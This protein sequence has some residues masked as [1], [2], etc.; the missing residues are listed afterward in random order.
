METIPLADGDL[1]RVFPELVDEL[2]V[3]DI[4][5]RAAGCIG[6][7]ADHLG[8]RPSWTGSGLEFHRYPDQRTGLSRGDLRAPASGGLRCGSW[9][10]DGDEQS[11]VL[12][13]VGS[14]VAAVCVRH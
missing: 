10:G 2:Q 13:G 14:G 7:L 8:V 3:R 9:E 6:Q 12:A 11:A 5:R 4:L 1:R